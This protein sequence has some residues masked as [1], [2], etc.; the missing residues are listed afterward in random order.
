MA[1]RVYLGRV[2]TSLSGDRHAFDSRGQVKALEVIPMLPRFSS[3]IFV[4]ALLFAVDATAPLCAQELPPASS[5]P[6]PIA[7][8]ADRDPTPAPKSDQVVIPIGTRLPLLL[9]N[10]VNTRTAKQGDSVYF[11]T[12]YPIAV[13]NKIAIPMGT[14]VRGQILEAKRPGR[15][16]GRGEFRI[17]LEQMTYPNGYTIELRATPSSVDRDGREG[18][19]R[20]GKIKR[21]SSK[22]RDTATVLVAS[23]GGAYIGALV[24]RIANDAPGRG[25]LIGGGAA[26]IGTLIAVLA[27]RGP[28]AELPRGTAMDVTFD[29]PLILD[30]AFLRGNAGAGLDPLA[31][32]PPPAADARK[33]IK[34]LQAQRIR[35]SLLRSI[36][37]TRF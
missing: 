4:F 2:V 17:A 1:F 15:I 36:L 8:T 28:E 22:G 35:Q 37:L 6:L 10:G 14:L 31:H 21:P 27:T 25:A 24:G 7:A 29:R 18:V 16:K 20:E 23:G 9:R 3:R 32:L 26:G 13:N 19:D 5:A 30:A 11:E 12:A 33:Q 34:E